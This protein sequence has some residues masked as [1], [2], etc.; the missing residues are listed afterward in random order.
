MIETWLVI[1]LL[2][3]CLALDLA[4]ITARAGFLHTSHARLLSLHEH[5]EARVARAV[6][7]LPALPR[8]RTAFNLA[9]V[10]SR[11]AL[12][13]LI[14]LF[15]AFQ[16]A[17]SSIWLFAG[18]LIL[19][20][21][22]LFW[23]E[24]MAEKL[25]S[26]NPAEWTLRMAGFIRLWLILA[27][28]PMSPLTLAPGSS[29]SPETS[30]EEMEEEVKTLVDAGQQEGSIEQ[31]ERRM[32]Y[33]VFELGETLVRE[34]MVPRTDIFALDVK[35]PLLEAVDNII[36]SGHSRVPVYEEVVD[37]TL[38]VLYAKDLLRV[39][40][41]G[42]QSAGLHDLLRPA[43]FVPEAKKVDDLLADMQ[44]HGVH[45]AIVVDEYGG[46]AGL[47]TLEDVVE[48]IFGE[49]RDEY[50]TSEEAPFQEL[51]DGGYLF[52]GRIDLDDFNEIMGSDL[53]KDE[54]DTLGGYIFSHLGRVPNIGE[55][56]QKDRLLLTV[57]QVS[58][59]RIRKVRARWLPSEAEGEK[60]EDN[61]DG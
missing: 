12:A 59:R 6:A 35:T 37:Q 55:D 7:L 52:Q 15:L 8:I 46:V 19:S 16:G 41:R 23:L 14:L 22:L 25:V 60:E 34:I 31:G 18:V 40:R 48:E 57:E 9:L 17:F 21:L 28:L 38:G 58:G 47:V 24:W 32:I 43:Y 61:V 3:V 1:A 36:K 30:E 26:R 39:S 20:A 13:G 56:V 2:L 45:M 5:S 50:D 11:F 49:I 51:K 33:S 54:D 10:M 4:M 29:G 27:A 44:A 53:V 42:E